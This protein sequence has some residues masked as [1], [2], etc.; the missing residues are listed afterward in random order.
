MNQR[1]TEMVTLY[2][3]AYKLRVAIAGEKDQTKLADMLAQL[4]AVMLAVGE[5]RKQGESFIAV[6]TTAHN[7]RLYNGIN[8]DA[9]MRVYQ[10]AVSEARQSNPPVSGNISLNGHSVTMTIGGNVVMQH[11]GFLHAPTE[12]AGRLAEEANNR[13]MADAIEMRDCQTMTARD[14]DELAMLT[15]LHDAV[16][17]VEAF[18]DAPDQVAAELVSRLKA[19]FWKIYDNS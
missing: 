10:S 3:R 13:N 2:D 11:I 16:Q 15:L 1:V 19:Q 12:L 18:G 14:H 5:L 9:A 4:N 6:T 7:Q 8:D 17:H